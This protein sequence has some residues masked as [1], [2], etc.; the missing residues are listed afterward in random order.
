MSCPPLVGCF[1]YHLWGVEYHLQGVEMML[2]LMHLGLGDVFKVDM[3]LAQKNPVVGSVLKGTKIDWQI[4][5]PKRQ[6]KPC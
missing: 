3:N 5:G 1:L 4:L 2:V 6:Q